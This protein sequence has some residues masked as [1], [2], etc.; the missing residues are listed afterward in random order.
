MKIIVLL[1][2]AVLILVTSSSAQFCDETGSYNAT[3]TVEARNGEKGREEREV[4]RKTLTKEKLESVSSFE[5]YPTNSMSCG[6][7]FSN[8]LGKIFVNGKAGFIDRK[9]KIVIKPQYK[10]AGRFSENLAPVEFENGKWGYIDKTGETVIKPEYDWALI[11]RE[12]RALIQIDK[13]WGFI[14]SA[15]KIVV[16]PQFD[17]ANSFSE[18][19]AMV[20]VWGTDEL[21]EKD[22]KVLKTGYI[23]KFGNW[24]IEPTWDGGDDFQNGR[25]AVS[26][27]LTDEISKKNYYGCFYIDKSGK[28]ISDELEKCPLSAKPNLEDSKDIS[29]FFEDNK[30]GYKNKAG[31]IIWKPTK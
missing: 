7:G 26:K 19:L 10:D 12:G 2:P 25:T 11:F 8:G 30:T 16:K 6:M 5:I 3:W 22:F 23:D 31:K 4:Y 13:K 24:I 9:G 15:G 17:H 28:K 27:H 29:T 21:Y 1:F 20:E 14:D 18:D